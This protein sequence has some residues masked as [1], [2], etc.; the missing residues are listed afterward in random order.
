LHVA[1]AD[2]REAIGL[3]RI[4]GIRRPFA[5]D[6]NQTT[7]HEDCRGIG[8][9]IHFDPEGA[10]LPQRQGE[11]GCSD[12]DHLTGLETTHPNVQYPLRQLQLGNPVIEIENG[13]AGAGVH[14]NH[15]A[16]KLDLRPCSGLCPE[17]IAGGQRPIE[18]GL[19]PVVLA[20][21]RETDRAAHIAQ[22][23]NARRRV[24][25]CPAAEDQHGDAS[26]PGE[27]PT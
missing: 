5:V 1:Q 24:R 7:A 15:R 18:G 14:A 11:I 8:I 6:L 25:A 22:T 13:N 17:T 10:G 26:Q 3:P 16:A 12:L 9:G 2:P 21:G 20:A 4:D 27:N 23:R 19:H